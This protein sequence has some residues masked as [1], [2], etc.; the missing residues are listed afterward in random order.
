MLIDFLNAHERVISVESTEYKRDPHSANISLPSFQPPH[1]LVPFSILLALL[2]RI[3]KY[4][5]F[6]TL[7][8][9]AATVAAHAATTS[10][11]IYGIK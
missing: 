4:F 6:A 7:L 11:T 3:M 9:S 8:S 5:E 10:V 1:A 2:Y